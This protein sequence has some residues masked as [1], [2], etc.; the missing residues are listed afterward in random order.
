MQRQ[1]RVKTGQTAVDHEYVYLQHKDELLGDFYSRV[2][3]GSPEWFTWLKTAT[4]FSFAA[5]RA[6][7]VARNEKRRSESGF[8][9]AYRKNEGKTVKAYIGKTETVTY[10]RLIEIS[11]KFNPS[12]FS[13]PR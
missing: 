11:E 1:R 13:S 9:Y 3:V 4:S 2:K 7:F 10:D 8:W 6:S 12:P 5:G